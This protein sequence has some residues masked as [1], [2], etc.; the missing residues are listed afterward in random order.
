MTS[1]R[2]SKYENEISDSNVSVGKPIGSLADLQFLR[3]QIVKEYKKSGEFIKSEWVTLEEQ[4]L[5]KLVLETFADDD[6]RE[7]MYSTLYSPKT[8]T[9][10]LAICKIPK[11]SGYRIINSM[12]Q[13][14]LLVP[15]SSSRNGHRMLKKYSS[16]IENV[17]IETVRDKIIVRVKF[18]KSMK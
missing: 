2:S 4:S 13:N 18:A 7:I 11:T 1:I 17:Q 3:D 16:T 6:K 15:T 9:E 8:I 5:V 12:I 10:M 14:Y